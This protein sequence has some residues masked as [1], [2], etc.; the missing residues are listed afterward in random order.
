MITEMVWGKSFMGFLGE[1]ICKVLAPF[2]DGLFDQ[3]Q[4]LSDLS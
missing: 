4:G 3:F 1:Y 2:E